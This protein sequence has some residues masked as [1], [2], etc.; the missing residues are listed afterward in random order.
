MSVLKFVLWSVLLANLLY[1]RA[2]NEDLKVLKNERADEPM[3][4][5]NQ[6]LFNKRHNKDILLLNYDWI[7]FKDKV[8][9]CQMYID[10][11]EFNV[12]IKNTI[13]LDNL[14]LKSLDEKVFT[15]RSI[16]LCTQANANFSLNRNCTEFLGFFAD[17]KKGVNTEDYA[18]YT[19]NFAPVLVGISMLEFTFSTTGE[20]IS[21]DIVVTQPRRIIDYLF[22]IWI[23]SFGVF[24]SMLMGILLDKKCLMDIVKMPIPVAIGF[25]CQYG[26]MPLVIINKL[27]FLNECH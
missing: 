26:C 15:F 27:D 16:N 6:I 23:Y 10:A 8:N 24:I 9:K 25:C 1:V 13:S 19:V 2:S 17:A 7:V 12:L 11:C 20:I 22:D 4:T 21:F 14:A 3:L 18:L 5:P